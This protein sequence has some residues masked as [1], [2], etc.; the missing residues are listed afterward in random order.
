MESAIL[1]PSPSLSL[2]P[3]GS[4]HP[5]CHITR[6]PTPACGP[7]CSLPCVF[8]PPSHEPFFFLWNSLM[9][10]LEASHF[11]S[12]LHFSLPLSHPFIWL[13]LHR[14]L[15]SHTERK[16]LRKQKTQARPWDPKVKEDYYCEVS[17]SLEII[18]K[19]SLL[20]LVATWFRRSG[21]FISLEL[22]MWHSTLFG[23]TSFSSILIM[24][25]SAM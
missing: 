23:H 24:E 5:L 17:V 22:S 14:G 21:S 12:H 2:L 25:E 4:S 18:P 16:K 6:C 10:V 9:T 19:L 15:F 7:F 8:S 3:V 13:L 20:F 1:S 11:E